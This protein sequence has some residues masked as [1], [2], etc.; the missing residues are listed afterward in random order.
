MAADDLIQK[1][2]TSL[3]VRGALIELGTSNIEAHGHLWGTSRTPTLD[4]GNSRK[5]DLGILDRAGS[6]ETF[7]R[8]LLPNTTYYIRAYATSDV[9]VSYSS[10][11]EFTTLSSDASSVKASVSMTS[12]D[13]REKRS[14]TIKAGA[15]VS[16]LGSSNIGA[17]GHVWGTNRAPMLD[18]GNSRKSDLGILGRVG[19]FE[20]FVRGS[21]SKHDLLHSGLCH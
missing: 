5:S 8:D 12:G 10:V 16:K 3:R 1:T 13:L 6:F 19:S 21:S 14:M 15:S 2:S 20:T 9:G 17:H 4:D 7:V 18:D 11:F